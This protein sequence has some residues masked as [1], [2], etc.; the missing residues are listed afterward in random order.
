MSHQLYPKPPITEA[1]IDIQF[2]TPVDGEL[3]KRA[4][5]R[6]TK[7][8]PN[9][10]VLKNIE[11]QF[12]VDPENKRAKARFDEKLVI[13]KRTSSDHSE[14]ALLSPAALTISQLA[15]YPGWGDFFGRFV[16]D[17]KEW[18]ASVGYRKIKR[19]GV[20]YI[21]RLD[22]P[23]ADGQINMM[24][25]IRLYVHT[26]DAVGPQEIFGAQVETTLEDKSVL[27]INIASM[28]SPLIDHLSL[29]LDI[30]VI[31]LQDVPQSD[32]DLLAYV[33]Q[34]RITKNTIF[35]SCITDASRGLFQK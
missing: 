9:E 26:P 16:R 2:E 15:P 29:L 10:E 6:F 13:N 11:F 33:E 35:E 22:I 18:K 14:I 12:D 8:Y 5:S 30:D 3:V 20:R 4:V 7:A 1:V 17:W 27:H 21:N 32:A 28:S 19:I 34:A 23:A 25:Y 24:N 31:R